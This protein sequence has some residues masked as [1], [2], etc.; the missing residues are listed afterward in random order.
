MWSGTVLPWTIS[1]TTSVSILT[2]T[3]CKWLALH[4]T[5]SLDDP[6][7][8]CFT[9]IWIETTLESCT[10]LTTFE[11]KTE[12]KIIHIVIAYMKYYEILFSKKSNHISGEIISSLPSSKHRLLHFTDQH[13]RHLQGLKMV[14]CSSNFQLQRFAFK[15]RSQKIFSTPNPRRKKRQSFQ[16]DVF[17]EQKLH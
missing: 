14:K 15:K 9:K 16:N 3:E 5:K 8:M 10:E 6:T 2:G 4:P 13:I 1:T 11:W 7:N 17:L 12:N